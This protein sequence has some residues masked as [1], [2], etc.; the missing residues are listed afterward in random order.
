MTKAEELKVLEKI[1]ALIK[2]TGDDSYI[3]MTFKGV[4]EIARSNIEND[5]GDAPVDDLAA[6]RKEVDRLD[7]ISRRHLNEYHALIADFDDLSEAYR[8]AVQTLQ[9]AQY[10]VH[11]ERTRLRDAVDALPENASDEEITDAV[12]QHKKAQTVAR[13]CAEVLDASHRKPLCYAMQE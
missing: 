11:C 10:Y 12:R 1:D 9:A 2:S 6:A 3:S 5:F 13:R 7:N 8:Y 4:V